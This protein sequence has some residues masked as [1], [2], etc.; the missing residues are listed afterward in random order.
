MIYQQ[1]KGIADG[2]VEKLSPYCERISIAGSVRRLKPEV[3]D[4]E[5]VARPSPAIARKNMFGEEYLSTNVF[6]DG[7]FNEWKVLKNGPRYKQFTLPEGINFDLFL[8]LPPAQFGVI[9]TI[10]TGPA[11]FSR[12][13][14]TPKYN[15]G[16]LPGDCRVQ[17]GGVYRRGGLLTM[18]E[19]IDFLN[20]LG[21]GWIEPSARIAGSYPLSANNGARASATPGKGLG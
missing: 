9:L 19:E 4:I 2:L 18:P 14:V 11:D 15:H 5:I 21:L 3:H 12:W 13:I 8:V 16:A 1:A 7:L 20:L 10:R 6:P 17:D